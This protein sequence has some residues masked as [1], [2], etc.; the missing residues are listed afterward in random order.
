MEVNL[1]KVEVELSN[2]LKVAVHDPPA[3]ELGTFLKA[4]PALSAIAK[5][6]E[7]SQQASEG[8]LGLPDIPNASIEGIYPLLA[9][10]SDITAEEFKRL[11]VWDGMAILMAF[12]ALVPKNFMTAPAVLTS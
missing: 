10:M 3:E 7:A 1:R 5:I 6:M 9:I 8:V 11:P 2:G 4:L 12:S